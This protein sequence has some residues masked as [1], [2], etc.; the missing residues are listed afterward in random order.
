[1]T[2]CYPSYSA[3]VGQTPLVRLP[4]FSKQAEL[5]AK[6]EARNPLG[7][8]KD[9][10]ALAMIETAE[11]TGKL[12]AGGTVIEPTSGNTGIGLAFICAERGYRLMLT[13][14]E[15][16][17]VERRKLLHH[18][19]AELILTPANEGVSGAISRAVALQQDLP[20]SWM[21]D[22]FTNPANP[23]THYRSTGP[24]IWQQTQG[25]VDVLVAGV[26]TGGTITGAGKYLRKQN[27]HLRIVA[28][29]PA[30][31]A[32]L[33]GKDAGA[34]RI[35]GIGAGF[36]PKTLDVSIID[37]V[38]P[39]SDEEAFVAA[40]ELARKQGILCGIS[41]G[42]A[43][44]ATLCLAQRKEMYGKRIVLILPD[45]GERYLSTSLME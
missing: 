16:M 1:M 23:A 27:P 40:R 15:S 3:S 44:A 32:V 24:E 33:S 17:S 21:P 31:S 38:L 6:M 13:M 14:P 12:T 37:E 7:S 26:G 2:H 36:I 28:V 19:G 8:V 4:Y 41:G 9:R 39:V 42:A 20:G 34:H 29:E 10:I 43:L 18:L 5:M 30:S 25:Q 45:T 11:K 35:Q 22:Q